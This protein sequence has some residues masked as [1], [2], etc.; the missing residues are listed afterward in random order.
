MGP[1]RFMGLALAGA[2]RHGSQPQPSCFPTAHA[3]EA[4]TFCVFLLSPPQLAESPHH[5]LFLDA[6]GSAL[7]RNRPDPSQ[8]VRST[9]EHPA[10]TLVGLSC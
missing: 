1:G 3:A 5:L 6:W 9:H 8:P 4:G 10:G 7:W 2:V